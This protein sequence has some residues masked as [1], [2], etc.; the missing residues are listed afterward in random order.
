MWHCTYSKN[1]SQSQHIFPKVYCLK[2]FTVQ[3]VWSRCTV[4]PVKTL[5]TTHQLQQPSCKRSA[6]QHLWGKRN[7]SQRKP[8]FIVKSVFIHL[9][10]LQLKLFTY[11]HKAKKFNYKR[12][13]H[14]FPVNDQG[15]VVPFSVISYIYGQ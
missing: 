9:C 14:I 12:F 13:L 6:K 5:S 7:L 1:N 11:F 8:K 15:D 4:E 2:H 10:T 3:G